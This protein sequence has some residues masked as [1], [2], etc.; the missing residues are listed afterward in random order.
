[1][2]TSWYDT[3]QCKSGLHKSDQGA[4]GQQRDHLDGREAT[5][6]EAEG[7]VTA[8]AATSPQAAGPRC[9]HDPRRPPTRGGGTTQT[10]GA[11][12]PAAS[13]RARRP[14]TKFPSPKRRRSRAS[15]EAPVRRHLL[16]RA[17]RAADAAAVSARAARRRTACTATPR[18]GEPR[19]T[20]GASARHDADAGAP[21]LPRLTA[22]WR[23]TTPKPEARPAARPV[24][25]VGVD[26]DARGL[27]GGTVAREDDAA[28]ARAG[29]NATNTETTV[30]APEGRARARRA[31]DAACLERA[32]VAACRARA[33]ATPGRP[34]RSPARGP[35]RLAFLCLA[36]EDGRRGTRFRGRRV[37]RRGR[38]GERAAW[39][40]WAAAE[41]DAAKRPLLR[42]R[43]RGACGAAD[44]S[45]G[46]VRRAAVRTAPRWP[47][48]GPRRADRK[49]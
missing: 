45:R 10:A 21:L 16:R 22:R 48:R 5:D 8:A 36:T 35:E 15:A 31:A 27:R 24:A 33:A 49:S 32:L 23:P 6:R 17:A 1:M 37:R 7:P 41:L 42:R 40:V 2:V 19:S 34:R 39:A 4:T 14:S 11:Q 20:R 9:G 25:D 13:A 38:V 3:Q 18:R 46:G 12:A 29:E 47:R 30:A 44:G 43:W 26:A 28:P